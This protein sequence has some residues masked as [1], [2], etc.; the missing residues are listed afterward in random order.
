M[1][2]LT[3]LEQLGP[4]LGGVVAGITPDQLDDPTP[5]ADFT[6]RGVLEHMI[7]GA[8]AFAAA[9]RGEEPAEPDL[10]DP[11]GGFGAV[12]GDLVAAITRARRARPDGRRRPFGEVPGETF[13]RFVVLDGLVHGWDMATATGQPYEPPDELVAAVDAFARQ[14]LDP[15]RDGGR[16]SPTPTSRP[17]TP[18]PSSAWPPTR[19]ARPDPTRVADRAR[20]GRKKERAMTTTLTLDALAAVKEKQQATWASGD[21][22]VIGTSLQIIGERLCEAVDVSAGQTGARRGRRQRQRV[23]RRRPPRLRRHRHRLRRAP[24]RAGPSAGRRRRAPAHHPGGRR[25]GPARS[26]TPAS[27]SCCRRSA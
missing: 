7:G 27:T 1:D 19:A 24:A 12:L 20:R 17:P 5:C 3:Q 22:A 9:Y 13:A 10:S 18:H 15:L 2:P 4:H 11:L 16:P 21:Y 26:R 23:A 8:T 6:V 25:R 14:A